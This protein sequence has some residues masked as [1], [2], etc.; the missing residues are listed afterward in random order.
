MGWP[1][2]QRSIA[3]HENMLG[4][5]DKLRGV[6]RTEDRLQLLYFCQEIRT[7]L[8]RADRVAKALDYEIEVSQVGVGS[9]A[10]VEAQLPVAAADGCDR[11]RES[12]HAKGD[13]CL[14][15]AEQVPGLLQR[16]GQT[17]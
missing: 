15:V 9:T 10:E 5:G 6:E 13:Q 7:S 12:A 14:V 16:N 1:M 2:A 11:G 4:S 17:A 3:H 8:G